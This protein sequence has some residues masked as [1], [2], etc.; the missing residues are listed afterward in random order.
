VRIALEQHDGVLKRRRK[1][2]VEAMKLAKKCFFLAGLSTLSVTALA[3]ADVAE[4]F[5]DKGNTYVRAG[6]DQGV[7]VGT[8]LTIVGPASGKAAERKTLGTASVLE[9]FASL[10]RVSLDRAAKAA[11]GDKYAQ[12]RVKGS[13]RPAS[14]TNTGENGGL[15][16]HASM[17]G[18][19]PE[20]AH[21]IVLYNDGDTPWSHCELRLPNNKRFVIE[22][23]RA[24]DSESVMLFKFNQDGTE[25][26][27]PLD[28]LSVKCD[29]G[30][31]KFNFSM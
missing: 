14:A 4:V 8:S 28:S 11:P 23:L 30:Q 10:A 2:E 16:G 5:V 31:A 17:A 22:R 27:R 24:G 19:G 20:A 18:V 26:D 29:E 13:V 3:D 1:R 7:Q 6:T 9:V 12:L 25:Y 21:K 15:K